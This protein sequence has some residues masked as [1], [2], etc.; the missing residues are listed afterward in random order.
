LLATYADSMESAVMR[1]STH[2][3]LLIESFETKVLLSASGALGHLALSRPVHVELLKANDA[4][5]SEGMITG[6]A[7]AFASITGVELLGGT[8]FVRPFGSLRVSNGMSAYMYLRNAQGAV[9]ARVAVGFV[10]LEKPEGH[11][12]VAELT[13]E[14]PHT[15]TTYGKTNTI[16]YA[17]QSWIP[18]SIPGA[19]G[20]FGN[21]IRSGTATLRFPHGLPTSGEAAVPFSIVLH[22]SD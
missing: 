3:T 22:S 10:D 11:Q 18:P 2:R 4:V 14:V 19:S 12:W 15:N 20:S 9:T 1:R 8:A 21:V 16:D 7:E 6:A 5:A 13:F 17:L